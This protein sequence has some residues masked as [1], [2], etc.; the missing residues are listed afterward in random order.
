MH[1]YYYLYWDDKVWVWFITFNVFMF[2]NVTYF[3]IAL[4]DYTF[5]NALKGWF[6]WSVFIRNSLFK[7]IEKNDNIIM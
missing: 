7:S 5:K 2:Y 6:I 3:S 1:K 4:D